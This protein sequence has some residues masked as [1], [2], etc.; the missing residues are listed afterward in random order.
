MK[1]VKELAQSSIVYPTCSMENYERFDDLLSRISVTVVTDKV[2]ENLKKFNTISISKFKV[3]ILI[4]NFLGTFTKR[5]FRNKVLFHFLW[6]IKRK[7]I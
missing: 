7:F 1:I 6:R 3:T 5:K 4:F 2:T